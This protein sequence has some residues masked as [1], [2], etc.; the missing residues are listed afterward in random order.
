VTIEND[1]SSRVSSEVG[2][3]T[4]STAAWLLRALLWLG[5]LAALVAVGFLVRQALRAP[6][7]QAELPDLPDMGSVAEAGAW[8]TV[9]VT[10]LV[11][12]P[13]LIALRRP[14]P[15]LARTG[16]VIVTLLWAGVS[17]ALWVDV[18]ENWDC[19]EMQPSTFV[20]PLW[21]GGLAVLASTA[22]GRRAL[23]L[24]HGPLVVGVRLLI[25]GTFAG[26]V[27][28]NGV[29]LSGCEQPGDAV[30]ARLRIGQ[31]R[32]EAL[33]LLYTVCEQGMSLPGREMRFQ[34]A[35]RGPAACACAPA[36]A[37]EVTLSIGP[38]DR[39][40]HLTSGTT[41]GAMRRRR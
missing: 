21:L 30:I 32:E 18:R 22:D 10:A 6:S 28:G 11:T 27:A 2:G 13:L 3:V 17:A 39:V 5:V 31:S 20:A 40:E 16:L 36:P 35:P 23:A 12:L 25:L 34:C 8:A 7:P 37:R 26:L 9:L 4:G 38:G 15:W 33:A 19:A 24:P 29:C 1:D 14:R 41:L